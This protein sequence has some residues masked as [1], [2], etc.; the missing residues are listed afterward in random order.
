M[1]KGIYKY[2]NDPRVTTP[3]T[4][5]PERMFIKL[6]YVCKEH[7]DQREELTSDQLGILNS[8]ILENQ[9]FVSY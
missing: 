7:L 4:F 5:K 9:K 1:E 6:L 8:Y 3:N 2:Y